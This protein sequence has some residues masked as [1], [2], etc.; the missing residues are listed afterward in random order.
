M[1]NKKSRHIITYQEKVA[2]IAVIAVI[3]LSLV[4][5]ALFE[6]DFGI[7][8][9]N[10]TYNDTY[11][12]NGTLSGETTTTVQFGSNLTISTTSTVGGGSSTVAT[13][14]TIDEDADS[15]GDGFPDGEEIHEGTDPNDSNDFPSCPVPT[16]CDG[17]CIGAGYLAGGWGPVTSVGE[18]NPIEVFVA[19]CC[20]DYSSSTIS[21]STSTSTSVTTTSATTTIFDGGGTA[22]SCCQFKSTYECASGMICPGLYTRIGGYDTLKQCGTYCDGPSTTTSMS[23]TSVTTTVVEECTDHDEDMSGLES[24]QTKSYCQIGSGF[25]IWDSCVDGK[26]VE[27]FCGT[28]DECSSYTYN[29]QDWFAGGYCDEG[30]CIERTCNELA[31]ER[32]YEAGAWED[33]WEGY[34]GDTDYQ[35]CGNYAVLQCANQGKTIDS[36]NVGCTLGG[37]CVWLCQQP[38]TTIPDC[39]A[40]AAEWSYSNYAYI[41]DSNCQPYTSTQTSPYAAVSVMKVD[42]CCMWVSTADTVCRA[43]YGENNNPNFAGYIALGVGGHWHEE[44]VDTCI[45]DTVVREY[46]CNHPDTPGND[47]YYYTDYLCESVGYTYC[48]EVDG[49]YSNMG[50]CG[51]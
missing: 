34:T 15:D 28:G 23:T 46:I 4:A 43:Y 6:F 24:L 27:W 20:C 2:L 45:S 41:G 31:L 35:K 25:E 49:A 38:T 11:T 13:T 19:G 39:S 5:L 22:Y 26:L 18:C 51:D 33:L 12:G 42:G 30:A 17:V 14:S 32:S 44:H 47:D 29:C 9:S 8:P 16:D 50:Y 36:W 7:W 37:C 48:R 1:A 21:T 40:T 3:A 10:I